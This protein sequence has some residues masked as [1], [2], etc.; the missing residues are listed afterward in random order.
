MRGYFG[1]AVY[2]PK[3]SINVGSLWRTAH[4]LGAKFLATIGHRYR[5]QA[6]DT[7]KATRHTPLFEYESF[8]KFYE[9]IPRDCKL[10][11]L[12]LVPE[13]IS[14]EKFSHPHRAIY[15]LGAEDHGLPEQVLARCHHL[16]RLPGTFSLNLA[17]A[18]S[19]VIYDRVRERIPNG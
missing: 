17:V 19:I 9:N 7:V 10:V 3:R 14:I 12:E 18:G 1:V 8:D 16:V 15:L 6:S 4:I 2:H 5:N 13:G 11:G